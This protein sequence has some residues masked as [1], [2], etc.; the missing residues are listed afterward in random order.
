MASAKERPS[1]AGLLEGRASSASGQGW[2]SF[3][4]TGVLWTRQNWL[5]GWQALLEA[6]CL[7]LFC[8]FCEGRGGVV[9]SFFF[10][11]FFYPF[12]FISWRL[13]TLQYYSGFCHTLTWISHG[14]TCVP[15]PD[16]PSP[17]HPSGSS[18]CTSPEHPASCIKPGLAICVT[19]GNIYVSMLFSHIIPPSPSP[20]ESKS[21]FFTWFC[22]VFSCFYGRKGHMGL[23]WQSSG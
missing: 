1:S 11:F 15:H 9:W 23:P 16:P 19:Y 22:F 6:F 4:G 8:F 5:L 7:V 18:Q 2:G 12:I 14:W 13:I 21:L 3:R 10:F 17:S 20:T